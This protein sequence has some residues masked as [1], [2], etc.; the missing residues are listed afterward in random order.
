MSQGRREQIRTPNELSRGYTPAIER[1]RTL[2]TTLGPPS[3]AITWNRPQISAN[4]LTTYSRF[5]NFM[6]RNAYRDTGSYMT[7]RTI[8]EGGET[9]VCDKTPTLHLN[10]SQQL[11]DGVAVICIILRHVDQEAADHGALLFAYLKVCYKPSSSHN[12]YSTLQS[13]RQ[14]PPQTDY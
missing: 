9:K 3:L 5:Q 7:S 10:Y 12:S 14:I 1:L 6:L 8:Y 11:Q 13:R 4:Y 2:I